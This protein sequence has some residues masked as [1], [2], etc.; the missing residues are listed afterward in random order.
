MC[1]GAIFAATSSASTRGV[2]TL[3]DFAH[4]AHRTII[5]VSPQSTP[6]PLVT[7]RLSD[8]SKLVRSQNPSPT[9]HTPPQTLTVT[10]RVCGGYQPAPKV[11]FSTPIPVHMAPP[12]SMMLNSKLGSSARAAPEPER[13][14]S[15]AKQEGSRNPA[16]LSCLASG[17]RR[18]AR[19]PAQVLICLA[20]RPSGGLS[21][22]SVR[23]AAH[24]ILRRRIFGENL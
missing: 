24:G 9:F 21:T 8:P 10:V 5:I 14:E 13:G 16:S 19:V 17:E 3:P 20:R 15:G 7:P 11:Y 23:G 22:E 1:S 6:S 12:Q 18:V 2:M 4:D